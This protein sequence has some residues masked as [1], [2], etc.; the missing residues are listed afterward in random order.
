MSTNRRNRLEP[1]FLRPTTTDV[2]QRSIVIEASSVAEHYAKDEGLRHI[3]EVINY[4]IQQLNYHIPRNIPYI[5]L[6][7]SREIGNAPRILI[8]ES[9]EEDLHRILVE[10]EK[11]QLIDISHLIDLFISEGD[12]KLEEPFNS[13]FN[14]EVLYNSMF[15]RLLIID[16]FLDVAFCNSYSFLRNASLEEKRE[17]SRKKYE[18]YKKNNYP[19]CFEEIS[20]SLK[21]YSFAFS[22]HK[23]VENGDLH[24]VSD[25]F[26][27]DIDLDSYVQIW[28]QFVAEYYPN[29]AHHEKSIQEQFFY[30]VDIKQIS[31]KDIDLFVN[32][33][34]GNHFLLKLIH[35]GKK[36]KTIKRLSSI[37]PGSTL[38]IGT[39]KT[40]ELEELEDY[41]DLIRN[42]N[43]SVFKVVVTEENKIVK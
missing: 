37:F 32:K 20:D 21:Y 43:I 12:F 7:A 28:D 3:T 40:V 33:K 30:H 2:L 14:V 38:T 31:S 16:I 15:T 25:D 36:E 29:K 35:I 41:T 18:F 5:S 6:T 22:C 13:R 19:T 11:L 4:Y 34:P 24:E 10:I 42:H 26:D 27:I 17:I 9:P 23:N 1:A 39:L 8:R